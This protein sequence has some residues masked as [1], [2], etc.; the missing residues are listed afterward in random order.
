MD[1][2]TAQDKGFHVTYGWR[3]V[4]V[5]AGGPSQGKLAIDDVII[6]LD[7]TRIKNSDNLASYLEERTLPGQ[8]LIVTIERNNLTQNVTVTLGQRPSESP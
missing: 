1:Y 4:E 8:D 3:V 2:E 5:I 7:G 6:A